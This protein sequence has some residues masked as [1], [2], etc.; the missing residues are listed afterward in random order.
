MY[1]FTS[2]KEALASATQHYKTEL[3]AIRTG[4]AAPALLDSIR[5]ESYGSLVPL[6]QVG[7]ITAEDARTLRVSAWDLGQVK[8]IETAVSEA[9]LGA[10]ISTDE[11]GVRI[12][13]P[14]LTSERREQLTKLTRSK[15]EDARTAV[16]IARDETWQGIQKQEKNKELSEDEK[17]SAK[18]SMEAIVKEVNDELEQLAKKKEQ[19]LQA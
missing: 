17:F 6:N 9:D 4:R 18:E 19:E 11:K 12:S 10:S 14:E 1:D 15:L 2:L 8:A 16:R 13:F 7:G 3:A 5:V